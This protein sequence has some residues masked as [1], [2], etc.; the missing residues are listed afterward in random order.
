MHRALVAVAVVGLCSAGVVAGGCKASRAVADTHA[1]TQPSRTHAHAAAHAET[2]RIA[3][4]GGQEGTG[5]DDLGFSAAIGK[6]LAPAGGTGNL[7]LVDPTTSAVTPISGFSVE[8]WHGGHNDG[9]TSVAA[10][11]G[12]LYATDRTTQTLRVVDAAQRTIVAS[13]GLAA[14]PDYVRF[15]KAT[16]EL[17]ITEP[18]GHQIEVL[19][20]GNGAAPPAPTGTIAMPVGPESLVVD[21]A[22]GRAYANTWTDSTMAIDLHTR[23][24]VAQWPNGCRRSRG[25]ALDEARGFVMVAC[26]EGAVSVL[27]V[28]SGAVLGH[29]QAAGVGVD[30]IAFAPSTHHLWAP[31]VRAEETT[32]FAVG[33]HGA[34]RVVGAVSSP[35]GAHCVTTDAHGRGYVCDPRGGRLWSIPDP[36]P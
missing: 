24:I 17:W 3:L 23:Q 4:P 8:P 10:H 27:D 29:A 19:A 20:L 21:E 33:D 16:N 28:R 2:V 31:S 1:R 15:V 32:V 35:L 6:V 7:D 30:I 34:L 25:L 5:F 12:T 9:V 11:G 13:V 18:P 22:H 26:G 36:A 14:G